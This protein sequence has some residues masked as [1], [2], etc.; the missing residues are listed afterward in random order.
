[1]FE[2]FVNPGVDVDQDPETLKEK[3]RMLHYTWNVVVLQTG[4]LMLQPV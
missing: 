3:C 4:M 2:V 1:M